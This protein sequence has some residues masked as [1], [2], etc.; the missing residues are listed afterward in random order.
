MQEKKIQNQEFCA[1]ISRKNIAFFS[2]SFSSFFMILILNKFTE[3]I[4]IT[5]VINKIF[6]SSC[7]L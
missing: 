6:Y 3:K 1:N 7:W 2:L 4:K 5:N